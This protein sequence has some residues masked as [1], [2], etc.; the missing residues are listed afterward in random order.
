MAVV[1]DKANVV[2]VDKDGNRATVTSL[3]DNDLNKLSVGLSDVSDLKTRVKTIEDDGY[4]SYNSVQSL[5]EEQCS[6]A[7]ANMDAPGLSADN[8]FTG[9]MTVEANVRAD[10]MTLNTSS[11]YAKLSASTN[12][13]GIKLL[14]GSSDTTGASIDLR[15][16]TDTD[17]PNTFTVS[18]SNGVALAGS[19]DGSL[20]WNSE[21]VVRKVNN[22]PADASG[23]VLL[24]TEKST[25]NKVVYDTGYFSIGPHATYNF[26]LTGSD[27]ELVPKENVNIRLVAK[28]TAAH[29]GFEV[30]DIAQIT[31]GLDSNYTVGYLDVCSYIRDNTFY[32]YSGTNSCLSVANYIA[33]DH[34]MLK[35]NVQIKAVLTAFIPDDGSILLIAEDQTNTSK[36]IGMPD[37]TLTW[38]DKTIAPVTGE[39]KYF[40][41]NEAPDGYLVCNGANV[42]RETY[43]DLFAVIG[44]TFGS[45]DGS[46]TFTLPNL[47]DKFAQGSTTV[48]AVKSAGLPNITG[49][50]GLTDNDAVGLNYG[51]S[52]NPILCSG[53]FSTESISGITGLN[54]DGQGS[55]GKIN[56][57]DASLSNSIYGNSTTVQPPALTLLP[58]IKY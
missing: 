10:S 6:Q 45:G 30:G 19:K 51:V 31:T 53:A 7:Q 41:F 28:V 32:I 24:G 22:L 1:L 33:P 15:G 37:G 14:G 42:S 36:L 13:H 23:N 49:K 50:F 4:V 20:T 26:D 57:F 39:I 48:G 8:T 27:L 35:A 16:S 18:A 47:I 54:A 40:A 9:N 58:C 38:G 43:A 56:T 44:T 52:A 17:A 25:F 11:D 55:M 34:P 2:L 12:D 3:T 5:D 21:N 46:T 29:N